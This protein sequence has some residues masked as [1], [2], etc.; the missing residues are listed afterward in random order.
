MTDR[1]LAKSAVALVDVACS[2]VATLLPL[3]LER[4]EAAGHI[5]AVQAKLALACVARQPR[6][7]ENLEHGVG[8][9][10]VRH[11]ESGASVVALVR[12]KRNI[13]ASDGSRVRYVWLIIA[14]Q[15]AATVPDRDLE[16]LAWMLSSEEMAERLHDAATAEELLEAFR[17]RLA[18]LDRPPAQFQEQLPAELERSGQL[19]GGL[20]A[21]I[22]RVSKRHASDI[23]DGFHSK[24]IASFVCSSSR[25]SRLRSR[26]A[27]S[28]RS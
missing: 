17:W 19:F 15:T 9:V 12:L 14:P 25:A 6:R 11:A 18:E 5:E 3:A 23:R 24:S 20:A 16:V 28:P 7:L 26:L 21:D 13:R 2:D 4:L 27:V 22:A 8:V 10:R 1:D